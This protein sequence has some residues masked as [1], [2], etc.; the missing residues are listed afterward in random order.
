MTDKGS[1]IV[2][3][4]PSGS[5]KGTILNEFNQKY[6][7]DHMIYSISATTRSPRQGEENGINYYFISNDEFEHK[8]ADDGF[9]EYANYCNNYYGTPKKPV[10]DAL[11][12]GID[13]MLE[14]ETVGAMKVKKNYPD[15]ILV[16]I[17]PPSIEELRNRLT[18]RG[19][20]DADVIETRLAAAEIELALANEYDYIIVNDN[21]EAAA[22]KLNTVVL[23]QRLK[24]E[25]NKKTILEVCKK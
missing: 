1:L 7:D 16:F 23:A 6:K 8:I 14:I 25:N 17:L 22:S 19:T 10:M 20:E 24:T 4:G 15:A 2:I 18:G 12:S 13:V 3:S 11:N 9:L 5:G 21:Y